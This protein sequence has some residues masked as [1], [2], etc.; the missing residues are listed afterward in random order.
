MTRKRERILIVD[1]EEAIRRLLYQKLSGEGYQC[2]AA[3]NADQALDE[4]KSSSAE[5]VILDIKMP[6]KSGTE[7]LPELKTG[8]PDTAVIM[9]TA[10]TDTSTAVQCMKAGA[11]DYITKPFNLDE[12]VL[13]VDRALEKRRLELENRDYQQHLE[14]KVTRRTAELR[15]AVKKIKL[16]S[17]DTIFRLSRAAE[18][19]DEDTG[20]HIQRMGRYS[21]AVARKMNLNDE[22]VETI[23]YASPMHD[24]GK[25]GIPDRI[26]LK[27]GKL[28]P[29]EWEIM[30]QHTIIGAQIL[31]DSDAEFIK[32]AETI[33]LTHH[34]KWDGSG[35]PKGLRGSEIPLVGHIVAIVDVFDALTSKR[36]YKEPL[37]LEKSLNIIKE[38]RES[39]FD[40]RVV[41]A[42][43]ATE[44]EI[45]SIRE[46]YKDERESLLAPV[47]GD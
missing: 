47:N 18:Y 40:P 14:Q 6:G 11:Y 2:Q 43:L 30:K 26:L 39:H 19:K 10:I 35:Y 23:L 37:P 7:L 27:P 24:I 41:T 20:D 9:A 42:F 5:L 34:E 3:G 44:G 8:Y 17:L 4:L 21:A 16:A 33:A 15:Q 12:V 31:E 38:G 25:I 45:L 29:G 1:D 13:S 28:S 36:P 22:T 32:L 46:K